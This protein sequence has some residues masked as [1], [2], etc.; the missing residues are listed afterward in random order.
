MKVIIDFINLPRELYVEI[1]KEDHEKLWQSVSSMSIKEVAEKIGVN[2][3][4][5]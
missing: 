5:L 2:V 3:R 1:R 4:N